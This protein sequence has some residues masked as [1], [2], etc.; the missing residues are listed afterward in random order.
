M[1]PP[2]DAR[3]LLPPGIHRAP[4]DDV[5][6][7]FC[8]NAHRWM[9]WDA[10]LEGIGQLCEQVERHPGPRPTLT[11]A[12]SFFS[13]KPLPADIEA[14]MTCPDGTPPAVCWAWALYAMGEHQRLK[15][16][17]K[18][19]FYPS[20]PGQNDFRAFFQYVG[21]KTA[22][23]KGIQEKDLRGVIEVLRW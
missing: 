3:G 17:H 18:L 10:A 15:R 9:L 22:A 1:I 23:D 13:D 4:L 12:G 21:P 14:T 20:L 16:E 2:L 8:T 6:A 7:R 11:L 19:D 5:P